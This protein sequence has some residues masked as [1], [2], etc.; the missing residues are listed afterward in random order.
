L[1]DQVAAWF[2]RQDGLR[3]GSLL[4]RR[5]RT[6]AGLRLGQE[7]TIGAEGWQVDRQLLGLPHGLRWTE[8]VD[9][10]VLALVGGCDGTVPLRD[11]LAVLAA[12]HDVSEEA[13][14]EVTEPIVAHLVERGFLEI[15][16]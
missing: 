4:D 6:A 16:P 13:L 10:L 7:A 5:Y 3:A 8:E 9:P 2:D 11:Q 14:A 12:A 15:V 1:G